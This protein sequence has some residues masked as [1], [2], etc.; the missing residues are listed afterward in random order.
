MLENKISSNSRITG[1]GPTYGKVYF[2]K[3]ASVYPGR[4]STYKKLKNKSYYGVRSKSYGSKG[5][6]KV[7]Q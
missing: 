1:K 2:A 7:E 3:Q 5:K 4:N 6:W